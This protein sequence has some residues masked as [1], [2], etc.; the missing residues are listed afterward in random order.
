MN[1]RFA[2][3]LLLDNAWRRWSRVAVGDDG[4]DALSVNGGS[5]GVGDGGFMMTPEME[6]RGTPQI[7]LLVLVWRT[8]YG[9]IPGSRRSS[10]FLISSLPLESVSSSDTPESDRRQW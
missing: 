9:M 6:T 8:A 5:C 10:F 1:A 7:N 4:G 3:T 2:N